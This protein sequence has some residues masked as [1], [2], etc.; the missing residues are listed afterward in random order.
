MGTDIHGR[1]QARW[2]KDQPYEDEGPIEDGRN[3]RVFAMLAGV[4]NGFG[5]AGVETHE[6][7]TPIS[8]PRGLPEGVEE[9]D[10]IWFGDHSFSWLTLTEILAWD[11]WEKTLA[12][13]GVV[14]AEE[15]AAMKREGRGPKAWSGGVF[16]G[17]TVVVGHKLADAGEPHTH[18]AIEWECP[19]VDYATVYRKWFDYL[20]AK[21][22]W[23]LEDD[24]AAVRI[25][26]GF[27]S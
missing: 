20:E 12:N 19:F 17:S 4:R 25:V 22:G 5:F 7:L 27:D 8:E 13:R 18:V 14:E 21:Y 15:Y 16:G 24:P 23:R 3:Y 6:P 9:S 10:D 26:F 11:G 2:G 1:I